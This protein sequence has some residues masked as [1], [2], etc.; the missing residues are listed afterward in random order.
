MVSY[1]VHR[2]NDTWAQPRALCPR[3]AVTTGRRRRISGHCPCLRGTPTGYSLQPRPAPL[4]HALLC[5]ALLCSSPP[6]HFSAQVR[7]HCTAVSLLSFSVPS[8]TGANSNNWLLGPSSLLSTGRAALAAPK[9][10]NQWRRCRWTGWNPW[11]EPAPAARMARQP[12]CRRST[13]ATGPAGSSPT[14]PSSSRSS[15]T[16]LLP[17]PSTTFLP[18]IYLLFFPLR[19][20]SIS[21]SKQR[22]SVPF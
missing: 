5:S 21:M 18:M 13:A 20:G 11:R 1:S 19:P 10:Q 8:P 14:P 7:A 2:A 9:S 3:V 4:P 16:L 15:G 17:F 6:W 12:N 22:L